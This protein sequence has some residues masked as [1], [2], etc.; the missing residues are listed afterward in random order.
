MPETKPA[1]EAPELD[2]WCDDCH[3]YSHRTNCPA[4]KADS[5]LVGKVV[6]AVYRSMQ[7]YE[8][9]TWLLDN[10]K[11][12]T[13]V[14]TIL[15]RADATDSEL[16]AALEESVKLQSHYAT[17]LNAWDGGQRLTFV[18]ADEWLARLKECAARAL[19]EKEVMG[20]PFNPLCWSCDKAVTVQE[21][22]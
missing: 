13:R 1:V 15:S 22:Q 16:R 3:G 21:G 4:Y 19:L 12:R 10:L 8:D 14:K 5:D 17:L 6:D 7:M 9:G 18:N 20:E 2:E 11:A